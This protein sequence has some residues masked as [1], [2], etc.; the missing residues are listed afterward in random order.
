MSNH[1]S[2]ETG[3]V[4]PAWAKKGADLVHSVKLKLELLEHSSLFQDGSISHSPVR[5]FC[6]TLGAGEGIHPE[7]WL[8]QQSCRLELQG[9]TFLN[10]LRQEHP[11]WSTTRKQDWG[12][13]LLEHLL[14]NA[15]S[16]RRKGC[17]RH[18]QALQAET[19][20]TTAPENSSIQT[21]LG[22]QMQRYWRLLSKST[23][24]SV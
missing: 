1:Q 4:C 19:A 22:P 15:A 20:E 13:F 24:G 9:W 8:F 12:L 10:E 6:H 16:M 2:W 23:R 7:D 3:V 21:L 11:G 5:E 18:S 17:Q 14:Q